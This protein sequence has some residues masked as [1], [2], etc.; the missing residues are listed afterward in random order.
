MCMMFKVIN[1]INNFGSMHTFRKPNCSLC[2]G[3]LLTILKN[4]CEKH[5]QL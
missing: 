2:V 3:K 4:I 5:A 1:H